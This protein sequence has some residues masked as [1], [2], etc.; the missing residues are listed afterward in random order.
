MPGQLG[1]RWR[2]AVKPAS[3]AASEEAATARHAQTDSG[4]SDLLERRWRS[5]N[6][7]ARAEASEGRTR[8]ARRRWDDGGG[9]AEYLGAHWPEHSRAD[10]SQGSY[11]PQSG[12]AAW[13][14]RRAGGGVRELG[15]PTVLDRFIQQA[16][17]QVLQPLIDP[18]FSQHSHGFRPGRS[19]HGAV[20]EAQRYM[21]AGTRIVVDVDLEQVLRPRQPRR[22]DGPAGEAHRGQAACCG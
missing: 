15:I 10:C 5:E 3:D 6:L 2:D 8:A 1:R 14:F 21:Q 13:A 4:T 20:L 22:A 9:A 19:A 11:R 18:S 12:D 16:L 7:Q 17:L